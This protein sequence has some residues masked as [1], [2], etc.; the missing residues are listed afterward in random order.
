GAMTRWCVVFFSVGP[1]RDPFSGMDYLLFREVSGLSIDQ[2]KSPTKCEAFYIYPEL[3]Y[4]LS[5]SAPP[6][7]SRISLVMEA[8]RALLY[9]NLRASLSS[10]ALSVALCMAVIRAPCSEA[11]ESLRPL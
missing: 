10:V 6:T 4:P 3:Y 7:I 1:D 9:D 5:A 8:C 2:K 11:K